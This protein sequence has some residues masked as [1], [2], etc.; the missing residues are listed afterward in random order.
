MIGRV[1]ESPN[2][3]CAVIAR[4]FLLAYDAGAF[5]EAPVKGLHTGGPNAVLASGTPRT[6]ARHNLLD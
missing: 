1:L 5:Y 3:L 6:R 4:Q 2:V